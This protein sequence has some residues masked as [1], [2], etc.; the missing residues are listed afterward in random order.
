MS[1]EEYNREVARRVRLVGLIV[2]GGALV[3]IAL[4]ALTLKADQVNDLPRSPIG[5]LKEA[6]PQR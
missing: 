1:D 2:I 6:P 5:G 3:V 4:S